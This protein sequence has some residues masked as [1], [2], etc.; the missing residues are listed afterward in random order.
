MKYIKEYM[1]V[2][3]VA[4]KEEDEFD[5]FCPHCKHPVTS[6]ANSDYWN[7]NRYELFWYCDKCKKNWMETFKL[8]KVEDDND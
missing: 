3:R 5:C 1:E 8:E 6:G 2:H 7:G 4:T